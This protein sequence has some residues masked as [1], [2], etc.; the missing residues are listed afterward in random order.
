M[1]KKH[2]HEIICPHCNSSFWINN[3]FNYF[4]SRQVCSN[5]K[6]EIRTGNNGLD[7]QILIK[8]KSKAGVRA[9]KMAHDARQCS[10]RAAKKQVKKVAKENNI[11]INTDVTP[12]LNFFLRI[13][14]SGILGFGIVGIGTAFYPNLQ[15]IAAPVVCQGEFNIE[16]ERELSTKVEGERSK[17]KEI[18]ITC[19][20]EDI[21]KKTFYVSS[22][23][24]GLIIFILLTIRKLFKS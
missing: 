4:N 21:T 14:I 23:M 24:Y 13:I 19:D 1:T 11:K 16:V 8:I 18:L 7:E 10:L 5:C 2:F 3:A 22:G 15:K 6:N 9:I 20:D 17:G 12:V